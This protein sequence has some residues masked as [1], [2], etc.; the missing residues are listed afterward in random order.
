MNPT[1]IPIEGV[2]GPAT[3]DHAYFLEAARR[4]EKSLGPWLN[5]GE[6]I[7]LMQILLSHSFKYEDGFILNDRSNVPIM[8]GVANA[9]RAPFYVDLE[10]ETVVFSV[11][12]P[13]TRPQGPD[14]D[15]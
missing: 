8:M 7:A 9:V 13:G 12:P 4:L 15:G 1:K 6:S 14:V 2:D 11:L 10:S 3:E 5:Y